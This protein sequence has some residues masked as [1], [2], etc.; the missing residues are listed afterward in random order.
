L[1]DPGN[2]VPLTVPDILF[3]LSAVAVTGLSLCVV[4]ARN[5]VRSTL[6]LIL[7]FLPV[8][9]MY[10][11]MRASFAG[12]LQIMVYAGAI[13]MLFTFVI[14]MINP[15]P[16][17]GEIPGEDFKGGPGAAS[18]KG[19]VLWLV[20]LALT[21]LVLIPPIRYAASRLA[22]VPVARDDF[23]GV[24]ALSRLIFADP[25]N[26]PLTV[27]FELISVLILVGVIAAVNFGRRS[28]DDVKRAGPGPAPT[29]P[30]PS[31]LPGADA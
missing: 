13:M 9:L 6:L 29:P 26:N 8:S 24:H 14:M 11:L 12:I 16:R 20:L 25:A 4:L 2:L 22:A 21:A 15:A 23:G 7:S 30:E 28:S 19:E 5:P 27:S 18:R 31:S 10:V 1:A 17:D 3:A